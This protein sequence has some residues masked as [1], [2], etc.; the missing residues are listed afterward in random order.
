M[1]ASHMHTRL[2]FACS[3]GRARGV[4]AGGVYDALGAVHVQVGEASG[5]AGEAAILVIARLV[6]DGERIDN[7]LG[8]RGRS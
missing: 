6:A 4:G 5:A 3:S 7:I 8:D 1:P 2:T